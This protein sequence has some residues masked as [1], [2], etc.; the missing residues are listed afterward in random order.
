MRDQFPLTQSLLIYSA[1]IVAIHGL[2]AHPDDTWTK[3]VEFSVDNDQDQKSQWVNWL[4]DPNMLPLAIP[5]A[6]IMRYGYE[7]A[8]FGHEAMQTRVSAVARRL[9][10]SLRRER[11][12]R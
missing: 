10:I 2:G 6:R 8:W 4:S 3:K 1:S 11:R 7:S 9:L 5:N 12:V